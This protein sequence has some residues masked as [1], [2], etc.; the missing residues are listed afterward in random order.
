MRKP[1]SL[2]VLFSTLL[3]QPSLPRHQY[4]NMLLSPL[5]ATDSLEPWQ[6]VDLLPPV[7]TKQNSQTE[8]PLVRAPR[9]PLPESLAQI[10][11]NGA[12]L[13]EWKAQYYCNQLQL[14]KLL[15]ILPLAVC[16]VLA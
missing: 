4:P 2:P 1:Q 12:I 5:R 10:L 11:W 15:E 3:L 16:I 9:L 6:I 13:Q 8:H 14:A 7:R